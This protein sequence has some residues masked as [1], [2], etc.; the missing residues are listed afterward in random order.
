MTTSTSFQAKTARWTTN[1]RLVLIVLAVFVLPMAVTAAAPAQ[2]EAPTGITTEAELRAAWADPMRTSIELGADIYLRQCRTGDPIRESA[3]PMTL[4]GNGHTIRQTCFEKRV[5]RQD[6]TGYL[7]LKDVILTRGGSDGPG[8]AVTTRGEI[9]VVDSRVTQNLAEEPGGGIFSMRRATIVRSVITG[10]LANDD[11]G[12]VY[13]RRGGVQVFDST[14]SSNLVDGS[15]GAIGSTG[16]ILVVRSHVDGNTTDGDGGAIYADEDGDVTV[17]DSTVDGSDA[18]GPG[19]AIWTLD[20]DVTVVN[21]TLNGNRADDRGGAIGGEADVTVI[22]STIVRNAAVAHVAGG[23]W[24]RGDLFVANS[25]ISNNYAEGQ[26]GG[27]LGRGVVRLYYATIL[28]NMASVAANVGAGERLESF[29]SI[30]GPARTM[31]VPGH[32]QPT[33]RNCRVSDSASFGHNFVTDASCGLNHPSDA[34]G[35]G[36]P[37][38]GPLVEDERSGEIQLEIRLPES[39]S[40]VIDAIPEADCGFGPFDDAIAQERHLEGL[41]E[42]RLALIGTDQ[43]GVGRPQGPACDVGAVEVEQ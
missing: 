11:G 23:I 24:A 25:T 7:L 37:M 2:D 29:G 16:D 28:D 27:V 22:N 5:L 41:I 30:I 42:D 19:G 4:N 13:A 6:G 31:G 3:R 20:G 43:R 26:G 15:G 10:N 33:E 12:G 32:V 1:L 8:A 17:I 39:G 40:P 34:V 36:S 35:Q 18:D 9:E 38:L 14:V 21:S